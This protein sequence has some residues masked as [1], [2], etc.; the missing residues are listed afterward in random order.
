MLQQV[1]VSP[2]QSPGRRRPPIP[3]HGYHLSLLSTLS[4]TYRSMHERP[5]CARLPTLDNAVQMRPTS[6]NR[7]LPTVSLHSSTTV[8]CGER[9][10]GL[11]SRNSWLP[12]CQLLTGARATGYVCERALQQELGAMTQCWWMQASCMGAVFQYSVLKCSARHRFLIL[13]P[14]TSHLG[15][16]L[17]CKALVYSVCTALHDS[18]GMA[19]SR[20][21]SFFVLLHFGSKSGWTHAHQ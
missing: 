21:S 13:R 18:V 17:S 11:A 12:K 19:W 6:M 4:E 15:E 7:M 16:Q 9:S 3:R 5:H 20:V 1:P 10:G 8:T 14:C 2:R